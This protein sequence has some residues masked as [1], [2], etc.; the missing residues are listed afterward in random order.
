MLDSLCLSSHDFF[1][2]GEDDP[3]KAAVLIVDLVGERIQ[4]KFGI[5]TT[6]IQVLAPM[7][8]GEVGV[9]N[10]NTLL[11]AALNPPS[12]GKAEH[13]FGATA[14]LSSPKST[15]RV[16]DR[17]MQLR[18]NYGLEVF[19]GDIGAV[20]A[21]DAEAQTLTVNFDGKATKY[22][23]GECDELVLAYAATIH[24]AQGSEYPCV[25]MP[26]MAQHYMML[27]RNLLYTAVTRAKRF[28]VIVGSKKAVAMAVRNAKT[29]QRYSGLRARLAA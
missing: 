14:R 16:G 3:A 26:L 15:L 8:R 24:K 7:R 1:F 19:N 23:W 9:E 11:Q 27:Q 2:F 10:L 18:N 5:A 13:K 25:V 4:N 22:D 28:V 17:V 6:D 29:R 21:I 20:T 12:P